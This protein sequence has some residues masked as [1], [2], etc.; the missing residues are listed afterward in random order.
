MNGFDLSEFTELIGQLERLGADEKK[1]AERVL[2][3]GS[4]PARLAFIGNM[5]PKSKK[6]KEQARDNVTVSKTKTAKKSKNKY[7]VIGALDQ[8]FVYLYY[9]ENGTIKMPA[10]PFT[11]KAYQ[12]AQAAASEPMRQA[13]LQEIDNHLR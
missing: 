7:R 10:R 3:A 11:E 6:D 8:K 12:A 1:V 5:P 2:D 9:I 13:L 4:E